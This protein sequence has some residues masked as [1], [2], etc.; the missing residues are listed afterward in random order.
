M[1]HGVLNA[2]REGYEMKERNRIFAIL[3]A[4]M[5][6]VTYMPGL[7]YATTGEGSEP[8][9]TVESQEEAVPKEAVQADPAEADEPAEADSPEVQTEAPASE[10]EKAEPADAE[11]PADPAAEDTALPEAKP[12]KLVSGGQARIVPDTKI[13]DSD[14]LLEQYFNS[15][16]DKALGRSTQKRGA[17]SINKNKLNSIEQYLYSQILGKMQAVAS[18]ED[19]NTTLVIDLN[20]QFEPFFDADAYER[21]PYSITTTSLG[22]E[23][24]VC[25]PCE[26]ENGNIIKDK[27]GKTIWDFT[28]EAKEDRKSTR[29]NSS[30]ITR[31]RMPSSA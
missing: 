5:M 13:A 14:E 1:P 16:V 10:A 21:F 19:S 31:S 25:V 6:V 26:D 24:A 8:D 30:H 29:L 11:D 3:L 4:I 7:A 28:E 2:F 27:D 22:I 15:E 23:G 17:K 18:G 12:G 9:V 20:E